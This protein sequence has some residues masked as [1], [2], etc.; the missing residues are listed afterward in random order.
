MSNYKDE[1]NKLLRLESNKGCAEC[2][3]RAPLWASVTLGVFLCTRC[4]SV[5][6]HVSKPVTF[7]RSCT[8]DIWTEEHLR[9]MQSMGNVKS[10]EVYEAK[11]PRNVVRPGRDATFQQV[12]TFIRQKYEHKLWMNKEE[13]KI[14][15]K[16]QPKPV[17][18][19]N[20]LSFEVEQETPKPKPVVQKP[21]NDVSEWL[22]TEPKTKPE[23]KKELPSLEDFFAE[24]DD[25]DLFNMVKT[26]KN[27]SIMNLFEKPAVRVA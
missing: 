20:L 8:L 22:R 10:R 6:R 3:Q 24:Q 12:E 23:P 16:T 4:A 13:P 1:V 15:P 14:Q 7:V 26:T 18:K 5:H 25:D 27:Q 19:A 11:M 2:D 17:S 21:K 9:K